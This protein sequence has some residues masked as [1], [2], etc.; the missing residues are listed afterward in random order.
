MAHEEPLLNN[1]PTQEVAH[2]VH[3]YERFTKLL[4]WSAI[5]SLVIAFLVILIIS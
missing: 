2:H 1:P 5:V 4:K 3:D